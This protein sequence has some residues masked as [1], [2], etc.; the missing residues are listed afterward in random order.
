MAAAES[1]LGLAFTSLFIYPQACPSLDK[2]HA[3][4]AGEVCGQ[5]RGKAA[6]IPNW[7]LLSPWQKPPYCPMGALV[8]EMPPLCSAGTRGQMHVGVLVGGTLVDEAIAK[9][10]RTPGSWEDTGG[11]DSGILQP[12]K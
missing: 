10:V 1:T 4:Q 2:V 7:P 3:R 5:G 9:L 6:A 11:R 12:G 8:S